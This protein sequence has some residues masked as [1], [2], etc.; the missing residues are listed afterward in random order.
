MKSADCL[1]QQRSRQAFPRISGSYQA[2][3][4]D[5]DEDYKE[6]DYKEKEYEQKG[7][8]AE[9]YKKIARATTGMPP[10]G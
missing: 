9:C 3:Q 4:D 7:G 10:S 2:S 8:G 5:E 6:K 1:W